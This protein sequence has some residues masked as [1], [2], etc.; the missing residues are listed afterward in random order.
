[1]PLSEQELIDCD[2]QE[3]QGCNGGLMEYAFEYIKQKG[4]ITTESYYPY[5]AN[6]GSCDSTK[7]SKDAKLLLKF[8]NII[9]MQL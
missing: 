1:V 3:N 6:D 8:F 5:T 9:D 7:V 2:N 4:G